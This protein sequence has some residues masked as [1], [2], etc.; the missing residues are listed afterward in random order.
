MTDLTPIQSEAEYDL[1]LKEAERLLAEPDHSPERVEHVKRLVKQIQD[2]EDLHYPMPKSA[3]H[4]M[5]EHLMESQAV[6][7][8][9]LVPILGSEAE[10]QA[11]LNATRP[12]QPSE[13][14]ALADLLHVTPILFTE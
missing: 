11:V 8:A 12:I 10:V 1:K 2:Y 7:A 6:S 4:E 5:L 9:D 14:Q 3:P 13:A